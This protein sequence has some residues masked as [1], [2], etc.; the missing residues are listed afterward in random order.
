MIKYNKTS[1]RVVGVAL[2]FLA[3]ISVFA[4]RMISIG[5][6]GGG[7]KEYV[8]T[9]ER[10]VPI[11]AVRGEIYDR[12]GEKLIYNTYT[13]DLIFDYEAMAATQLE[14]NYAIIAVSR[15]IDETGNG[16]RAVPTSFPFEGTYP[17]YTFSAEA[18]DGESNIYYRLLKRI[19][20]N[21]LEDGV[22]DKTA[23]S[24]DELDAYYSKH[25][26]E[27]PRVEELL[28]Y[29]LEKYKLDSVTESG[30]PLFSDGDI[31]RALRMRYDMEVADF[32]PYNR[33]VVAED[34][35]VSFMSYVK[36]LG[37]TG[38]DFEIRSTRNYAYPGY[39]SHIL[40][41]TGNIRAEDWEYYKEL[42]YS[43]NA[44][45]GISGC[46]KAFEE[47]LRGVDG[48]RVVVEDEDGRIIDSYVKT[49]P[50]AGKD[51]YLTIDIDLQIAAE[52]GLEDTVE[53]I[54]S[55]SAGALTAQDPDTG[56]ILALAS[57]PTY[58]L[59]TYNEDYASLIKDP[60]NPLYNRA[61][62]GL[63]A[64]GS[65]FKLGMVAAGITN[66]TFTSSTR[67]DCSGVY[68]YYDDYQPKCWIYPGE[69]G[70]LNAS[71]ALEVSC[72][73]YF[74]ELGRLMGIEKMNEYC[75]LYGLGEHTGVEL[76]DKKG[77]LAGPAYRDEH[78][79]ATWTA[80]NTISAAIGQ[81]D[82][83]FTPL[84]LSSYVSTLLN[85]G[86]RY[87]AHL[88]L[89][90]RDFGSGETTVKPAP[91]VLS[92]VALSDEA[93]GAVKDGMRQMVESSSSVSRYMKNVPV[94]V[95]GKTGTAQL[96]GSTTD[97]G[98]FVCAA[99]YNAPEIVV[100]SVI[101]HS[102]GGTYAAIAASYVLEEYYGVH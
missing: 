96:G 13:Y 41:Q 27:F 58:D 23:L 8:Y 60:A 77:I 2:V 71:G 86:D 98:I 76:G 81:S 42:G 3:V 18:T 68:T 57:Y 78:G 15:A 39:A 74:Y 35:D 11:R 73:C 16:E 87:S 14:R 95:G 43:M 75:S 66:G 51:V 65:T 53:A 89:E 25:P 6:R 31:D 49:E 69:H 101:E 67:V 28:E 48:V 63:Y 33:Y 64:P 80:G 21:E 46:E 24:L 50:I 88:L 83:V 19:I 45:V 9:Y 4:V 32:S 1:L 70:R 10:E 22:P 82:N 72:N 37:A 94:T 92:H 54:K 20:E 30:E 12:N 44:T 36:E 85:G 102:G 97:N 62:D 52:R 40:G 7:G 34:V 90:V 26:E 29:F 61:L 38:T 93:V 99:P 56:E 59:T 5:A 55:S 100:S 17:S 84:Q 91:E 79:Y 47:Y